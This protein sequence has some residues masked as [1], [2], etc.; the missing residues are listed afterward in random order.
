MAK[1]LVRVRLQMDTMV[2]VE[3]SSAKNQQNSTPLVL[4]CSDWW[5]GRSDGEEGALQID[6]VDFT[7]PLKNQFS[8]WFLEGSLTPEN[9]GP[10]LE[11]I[12]KKNG[13]RNFE[14]AITRA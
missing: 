3:E 8:P 14:D 7:K 13:V 6:I 5:N 2:Y 1:K 11:Q 12:A 9:G 4:E 10:T